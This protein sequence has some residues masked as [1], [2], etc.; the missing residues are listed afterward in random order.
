MSLDSRLRAVEALLLAANDAKKSQ[1]DLVL[2]VGY[3]GMAE[4]LLGTATPPALDALGNNVR[5]GNAFVGLNYAFPVN[6]YAAQGLVMQQS[7][8][9]EQIQLQKQALLDGIQS[10]IEVGLNNLRSSAEQFRHAK[11]EVEIQ[12]EVCE[13][14]KKKYR[15]GM[16]TLLDLFTNETQL[17]NAQL[18]EMNAQNNLA[19]AIIQLRF[20]TGTLL[21][22]DEVGQTIDTSRLV[23]LPKL[24]TNK[25]LSH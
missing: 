3:N 1:L 16:T 18:S 11:T 8:T 23:T 19:K 21:N 17:T 13:S 25:E 14:E 22:P 24:D 9:L 4:R 7:A 10:S 20:A 6:N 15:F 5:G 2:S 12:R